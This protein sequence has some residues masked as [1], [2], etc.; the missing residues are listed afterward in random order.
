MFNGKRLA[1][2]IVAW[3]EE[4]AI[5]K[6]V[7]DFKKTAIVDK[8]I[9]I[10][11]NSKDN[12]SKFAK[13]SGAEVYFEPKQGYGFACQRALR[14]AMKNGDIIA[15]VEG[16]ASFDASDLNLLLEYI[17]DYDMVIGSRI[18]KEFIEK[19]AK[20]N[21]FLRYGNMFIGKLMHIRHGLKLDDVGCTFRIIK[22]QALEKIID[23]LYVGK[24]YF[25]PHMILVS[26]KNGLK[27]KEIPVHYKKRIGQSTI[28]TNYWKSF[29]LGLRMIWLILAGR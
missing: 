1:V 24:S 10:D 13:E 29:K 26:I 15:L 4:Q 16:D 28:T 21:T 11:N 17:D 7:E 9:V 25:S 18:K 12:T 6:V 23:Q 2:S 5:K 22:R 27:I 3:N 8:L 20:M 14:E 19:G